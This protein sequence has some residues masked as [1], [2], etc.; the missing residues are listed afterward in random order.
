MQTFMTMLLICSVTMSVLA[1][2]YM[3]A[4][5]IL[6]N[7]YS[8]KG[9]YYTWFVIVL[10]LIIPFR[11]RW[12][13]PFISIETSANAPS[14]AT[15]IHVG[16]PT[17]LTIPVNLPPL[18]NMIP[19]NAISNISWW[20]LIFMIWFIG[21][22]AFIIYHGIKHMRFTKMMRRW[23]EPITSEGTISLF[24]SLK[25]E[26]GIGKQIP[27]YLC[28]YLSS[29]MLI[30]IFKSRIYLPT[31]DL[32]Q[33]ELRF[34]LKHELVHYKRRDL[35]YK[36]IIL[37]ARAMHWF[38]PVVHLV[39]KAIEL[40]CEKS[41]DTEVVQHS[42]ADVRQSYGETIIG[43]ATH[44][45]KLKTALS[46]E[47][48]SRKKGIKSRISIIMDERKKKAGVM[49]TCAAVVFTISGGYLLAASPTAGA[50]TNTESTI[51]AA[52][53]TEPSTTVIECSLS[54]DGWLEAMELFSA[55][56]QIENLPIP[57][58]L[59]ESFVIE[60]AWLFPT[61]VETGGSQN[62]EL[63]IDTLYIRFSN[64][65]QSFDIEVMNI[66]DRNEVFDSWMLDSPE[67]TINGRRVVSGSGW[68]SIQIN[69][70]VRY[71]FMLGA[72]EP[73]LIDPIDVDAFFRIVESLN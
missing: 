10:A 71:S 17:P 52:E 61:I 62:S 49:L 69:D 42:N 68:L 31:V 65:V 6:S 28:P 44:K 43:V 25:H 63:T 12:S 51:S 8:E 14:F 21:A 34:I 27:I 50:I 33:D 22:I 32:A 29:P 23:S 60:Y 45:T 35:L 5:P 55:Q 73:T 18:D 58:Y 2:L 4:T 16:T 13:N 48:Y 26:M 72:Y 40:L 39:A 37:V 20:Q 64:G 7:R 1:V 53:S 46:T 24:K 30:G 66:S 67:T 70:N 57:S 41:C 38:N 11:P 9:R 56:H 59:P 47:F 19:T 3:A 54:N 36:H 15:E